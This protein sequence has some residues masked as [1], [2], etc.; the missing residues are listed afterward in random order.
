FSGARD[1]SELRSLVQQSAS[2]E[3]QVSEPVD[4]PAWNRSWP[5][6]VVR[7]TSLPTWILPIAR[8]FAWI[9]VDGR[10]NLRGIDRPVLFAANHTSH[11][12]TP[13]ILAALPPRLRYKVAPAMAKE[14]FKAH[15]FPAN[16]TRR[17]RFTNGLNYYLAALF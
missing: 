1:L 17:E 13:V 5:A 6:R 3:T 11:M 16:H 7:R 10:E 4:F 2:G 8:I 15:F 9:H 14:F 12:D